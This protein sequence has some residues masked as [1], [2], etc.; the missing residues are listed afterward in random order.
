MCQIFQGSILAYGSQVP[1]KLSRILC[2][3]M[4]P[5]ADCAILIINAPAGSSFIQQT[6]VLRQPTSSLVHRC[7][8][9]LV[10]LEY[11]GG[12]ALSIPLGLRVNEASRII[13]SPWNHVAGKRALRY[14]YRYWCARRQVEKSRYKQ[15]DRLTSL[16]IVP[17]AIPESPSH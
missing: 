16:F 11:F 14:G 1:G 9:R 8:S 3:H 4:V 17:G 2:R 5:N 10:N 13:L 12:L 6:A 15:N 7:G